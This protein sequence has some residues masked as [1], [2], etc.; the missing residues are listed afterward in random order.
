MSLSRIRRP[1]PT[2]RSSPCIATTLPQSP[3]LLHPLILPHPSHPPGAL[4]H[5]KAQEDATTLALSI[6]SGSVR[7]DVQIEGE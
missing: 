6:S 2:L 5:Q 7:P 4:S 1:T 3:P